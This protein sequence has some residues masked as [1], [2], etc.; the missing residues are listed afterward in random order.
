[1]NERRLI[2]SP[3]LSK[4]TAYGQ[5]K[6]TRSGRNEF[7]GV[8]CTALQKIASTM[9]DL[10]KSKQ[11]VSQDLFSAS[12]NML[13]LNKLTKAKISD[14]VYLFR[15]RIVYRFLKTSFPSTGIRSSTTKLAT[16]YLDALAD[17]LL[18]A[19]QAILEKEKRRI[20]T[21]KDVQKACRLV[22]NMAVLLLSEGS[23]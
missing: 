9:R 1:M 6:F 16:F 10:H 19:C 21:E 11:L 20:I 5:Q 2:L 23:A 14:K 4:N 12:I 13:C 17:Q 8:F 18:L 15:P 3:R 22:K 7:R